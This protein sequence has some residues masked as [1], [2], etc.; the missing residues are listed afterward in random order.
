MPVAPMEPDVCDLGEILRI[1]GV[2]RRGYGLAGLVGTMNRLGHTIQPSIAL[3]DR[4]R[5]R[6]RTFSLRE[7]VATNGMHARETKGGRLTVTRSR[8]AVYGV[9]GVYYIPTHFIDGQGC[10]LYWGL[11]K[12]T[13]LVRMPSD[14]VLTPQQARQDVVESSDWDLTAMYQLSPWN[15]AGALPHSSR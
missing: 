12:E 5:H 13:P 8:R 15:M 10:R 6:H 11:L 7:A 14:D 4:H 2:W 1:N 3:S 9:A